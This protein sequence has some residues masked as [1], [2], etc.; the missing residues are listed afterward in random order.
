MVVTLPRALLSDRTLLTTFPYFCQKILG[1]LLRPQTTSFQSL[2]RAESWARRAAQWYIQCLPGLPG[3]LS[4]TETE[5][6][7]GHACPSATSASERLSQ[8]DHKFKV[9]LGYLG[10]LRPD[11]VTRMARWKEGGREEREER[12]KPRRRERTEEM[13]AGD[14]GETGLLTPDPGGQLRISWEFET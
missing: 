10:S 1:G 4:Y 8:D 12:E 6:G 3:L 5:L 13:G 7:G 11:W 2:W 14:L 9:I